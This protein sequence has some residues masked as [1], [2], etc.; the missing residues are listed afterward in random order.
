[1]DPSIPWY[2][3]QMNRMGSGKIVCNTLQAPTVTTYSLT[4]QG[5]RSIEVNVQQERSKLGVT[6][7]LD[8]CSTL[9]FSVKLCCSG[10]L[11][12]PPA[13]KTRGW[14][15]GKKASEAQGIGL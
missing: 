4:Q 7:Q 5:W 6:M 8:M 14:I 3:L 10:E 1:M 11:E 9:E 13:A 15:D 2:L 12:I